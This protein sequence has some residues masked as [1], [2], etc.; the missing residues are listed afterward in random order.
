M[1]VRHQ[2]LHELTP[3]E[4]SYLAA[5]VLDDVNTQYMQIDDGIA[6]GLN[7]KGI[8]YRASN[9]GDMLRGW[10][11]NIQPWAKDYLREHPHLL[12]GASGNVPGPRSVFDL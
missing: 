11:Y 8:I 3:D 10:A 6:G 1:K 5:Y 12:D 4:K 9:V 7:A 2:S